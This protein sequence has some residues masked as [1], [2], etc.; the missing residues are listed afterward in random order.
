VR[1]CGV[2]WLDL[3]PDEVTTLVVVVVVLLLLRV[4]EQMVFKSK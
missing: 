4:T 2:N 1:L 3:P